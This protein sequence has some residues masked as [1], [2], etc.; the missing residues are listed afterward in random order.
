MSDNLDLI[1]IEKFKNSVSVSDDQCLHC[2]RKQCVSSKDIIFTWPCSLSF[3]PT[4]LY[5]IGKLVFHWKFW[6]QTWRSVLKMRVFLPKNMG[7]G[8][9]INT[10]K[11]LAFGRTDLCYSEL[12]L[13]A[14]SRAMKSASKVKIGQIVHHTVLFLKRSRHLGFPDDVVYYSGS[15]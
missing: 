4:I 8:S 15:K 10:N 14:I 12:F 5:S 3:Y 1:Q 2:V 9:R 6:Y 13:K 7:C 11:T